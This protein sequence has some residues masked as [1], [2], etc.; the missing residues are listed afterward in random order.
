VSVNEN[1]CTSTVKPPPVVRQAW[2]F[3]RAVADFMRD[4]MKLVSHE[5]HRQPLETC[6]SCE[7]R[8]GGRCMRC[9]CRL[10]VKARG[11]AFRCPLDKWPRIGQV[12]QKLT[13]KSRSQ[14]T[15]HKN[16]TGPKRKEH[17][18]VVQ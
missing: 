5:E 1:A 17:R 7:P 12:A 6:D 8:R 14:L 4:G 13:G 10:R 16:L 11:H 3:A 2:N 18:H 9:G 15:W